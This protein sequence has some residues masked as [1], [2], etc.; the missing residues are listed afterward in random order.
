MYDIGDKLRAMFLL[1]SQTFSI[2]PM[3]IIRKKKKLFFKEVVVMSPFRVR[4]VNNQLFNT[5]LFVE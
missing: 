2:D 5:C 3:I 4:S 1:E